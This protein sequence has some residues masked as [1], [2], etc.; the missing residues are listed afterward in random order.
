MII[1]WDVRFSNQKELSK[2]LLPFTN[3]L[4]VL[5][6]M[7]K[8]YLAIGAIKNNP[9]LLVEGPKLHERDVVKLSDS[10]VSALL[11]C[12][13]NQDKISE[14][15]KAYNKRMV[16]RDMAIIMVLLGIGMRVSELVELNLS[17]IDTTEEHKV[18]FSIVRKGGD[19]DKVR[20]I[21]PVYNAVADYI[22][23]SRPLLLSSTDENYFCYQSLCRNKG[24]LCNQRCPSS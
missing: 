2:E 19:F 17:D 18:Y 10:E 22:E 7:Y 5:K 4:S 20:V 12:I 1:V 16:D 11:N 21:A 15:A 9:T 13:Q 6:T 14:H 24:H 8:Y 3:K 23:F